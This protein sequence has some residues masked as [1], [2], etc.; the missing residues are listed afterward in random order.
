MP[1]P[2]GTGFASVDDALGG[3]IT[4]DNVVWQCDD[5]VA[6]DALRLGFAAA[7]ARDGQRV[8]HVAFSAAPSPRAPTVERLDAGPGSVHSRPRLLSDELDRRF[9]DD[10]P[11]CVIVDDLAGPIRRWG[12]AVAL[13]FF[14]RTCPAMLQAGVTAYW[15]VGSDFGRT[16]LDAVRQITQCYIEVRDERLRV[17]KAEGRAASQQGVSYRLHIEGDDVV[18]T[19]AP[20]GG[21][22]ARGLAALRS[23]F[24]LTQQELAT[25]GGVTAS[26][27]S[28][29]ESGA[30]GLSVDTL[31][32][33]SDELDVPVDRLVNAT[34]RPR[35][36]LARHDRSRRLTS[37]TVALVPDTSIGARVFLIELAGGS[38]SAPDH[39]HHGVEVIAMMNGLVQIDLGDDRP[40]LRAGD[41]IVVADGIVNTWRNLRREPARFFRILR[42]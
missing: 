40:V 6:Y 24:R 39:P 11:D 10:R 34:P 36:H 21:R 9:R 7:A 1:T 15:C 25:I 29:A 37:D 8:L 22:L 35:Y 26:A 4:G 2:T 19:P 3:L 23:D 13:D 31:L 28:Q 18:A 17:I 32:R 12:P 42:D 5:L 33:I 27:I 38:S 16:A 41:T 30:R 20:T 14:S